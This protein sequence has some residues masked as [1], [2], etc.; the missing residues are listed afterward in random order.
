MKKL[1]IDNDVHTLQ[2]LLLVSD[3]K[4]TNLLISDHTLEQYINNDIDLVIADFSNSHNKKLLDEI[5]E[6]NPQQ[7][8]L[9][10]SS[11]LDCKNE[12]G[13]GH[14]VSNYNRKRLLKPID[15]KEMYNFLENIDCTSCKYEESQCFTYMQHYLEDILRSY[16]YYNYDKEKYLISK[17]DTHDNTYVLQEQIK[18]HHLLEKF[19]IDH[20]LL[21]NMD[22]QIDI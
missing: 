8:V 1:L 3:L 10:I 18:I 13:C 11:E 7:K 19:N 14:C 6:H 4:D 22:I 20:T 2:Q 15:V 17:I 9:I 12:L 5:T 21:D 16:Q